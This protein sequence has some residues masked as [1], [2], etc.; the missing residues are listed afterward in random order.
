MGEWITYELAECY[1][2]TGVGLAWS[3]GDQRKEHF[4]IHVSEDGVNW[5]QMW[6][7]DSSGKTS[8]IEDFK[9]NKPVKAK[10]VKIECNQNTS[11]QMNS[12]LETHIYCTEK[13]P[14]YEK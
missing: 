9:F 11:N 4:A 8:G 7:G 3:S 2:L 14:Y 12:L 6:R 10:Y 13:V 5:T 1:T